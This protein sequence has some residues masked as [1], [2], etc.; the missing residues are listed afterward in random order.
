MPDGTIVAQA[1]ELF[2]DE[3]LSGISGKEGD[4][5]LFFIE[6]EPLTSSLMIDAYQE[7][8]DFFWDEEDKFDAYFGHEFIPNSWNHDRHAS[9]EWGFMFEQWSWPDEGTL[10]MVIVPKEDIENLVIYSYMEVADPPP[11]LDDMTELINGI[12]VTD[13][14][15]EG[16]RGTPQ[17]D[18][19]LYYYVDVAENL[20]TLTVKT[21][22]GNGNVDLAISW[23]TVPDPFGVFFGFEEPFF[24]DEGMGMEAQK[25]AWDG[26]PGNEQQVTLYDVEPGI[27][28][29]AAYTYGKAYDFT[30]A[31]ALTYEPENIEPADAIELTPGVP[32][33]PLSGYDG[34]LQYFKVNVPQDTERLEVDLESGFGEAS[35]FMKLAEAPTYSDFTYSSNSPGAGDKIGFNDPTPGM[36]YILLET[37]MVFGEVKITASFEDRY[38]WQYDGTPIQLFNGDEVSGIEAPAGESLNFFVDLEKPGDY[39][40]IST[41][42]GTGNLE[43]EATGNV[44]D[45]GFDDFFDFFDEDFGESGRQRPGAEPAAE[46]VSINSDG[47]NTEQQI[48]INLPA[49]GRFD[50][51]LNAIEDISE[52]S[53]I[54]SWVYSE[55]ID[56]IEEPED[57]VITEDCRDVA[58]KEMTSKD[59]DKNGLLSEQEAKNILIN[60]DTVLFSELDI[61]QDGEIEF[62]EV[63]QISCTCDNEIELI[64]NQL[65]PDNR[66]VSIEM[67]SSQVYENKYNFFETDSNSNLRISQTEIE[68][69]ALL[70]TTTFDAFDGDGDGVPDV[71][72][73]FPNDPD[74]SKD[75]DGDGVGDNAD[76][77]PSIAND[78]IYSAGAIMAIGLLAMLVLVSRN[79][80]NK[81]NSITWDSDK[82]FDLSDRM[83]Q[84]EDNT[85]ESFKQTPE[86]PE[87]TTDY[88]PINQPESNILELP[89]NNLVE[90]N[91]FEQLIADPARPPNQL[92]GM[93]DSNGNEVL[94][95]PVG[96]GNKWQRTDSTQPWSKN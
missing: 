31:A 87:Q 25:S 89:Q 51:T 23:G 52:V 35:L 84:M 9:M 75:S 66:E 18:R 44:I 80:R 58:T 45:F 42:G 82:Q 24:E 79:S 33:G 27:Y 39:L 12:P 72:D 49:N 34:L 56:P 1:V 83:M 54:A 88:T 15:I 21:Y 59:L 70:C 50:I 11:E 71:D 86:L 37:D 67:L 41:Y 73:L 29:V 85:S 4:Q 74:E 62:A 40:S 20:S 63:L 95:F 60:G 47:V 69:L 90:D 30:I 93:I 46:Q 78:L 64:F 17:E 76:L 2:S 5:L 81:D 91:L 77:A 43:L 48:F 6:I 57:P 7:F 53:I 28:Y 32:Y 26:G 13:Q 16:G 8:E 38:V 14:T 3:E 19:I 65:S 92:L 94:E 10:W 22:S 96:S 36:W 68:I 61:N 55:F